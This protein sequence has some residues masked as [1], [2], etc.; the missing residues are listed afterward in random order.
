MAKED[1][2][3]TWTIWGDQ[4]MELITEDEKQAVDRMKYM[5]RQKFNNIHLYKL[6]EIKVKIAM[7]KE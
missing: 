4:R 2:L 1:Y 6:K 7:N 3:L 5:E